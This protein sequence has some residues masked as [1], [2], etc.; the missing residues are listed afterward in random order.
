[1]TARSRTILRIGLIER[2]RSHMRLIKG[3]S[4]SV[5]YCSFKAGLHA[6]SCALAGRER[7]LRRGYPSRL[8]TLPSSGQAYAW[9]GR[10]KR[11]EVRGLK[12]RESAKVAGIF[13][14]STRCKGAGSNAEGGLEK[15]RGARKSKLF[16]VESV[17]YTG[18]ERNRS[19]SRN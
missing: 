18:H 10:M 14:I 12:R 6:M 17:A 7:A 5:V 15:V 1:M 4:Q 19:E 16:Y 8:P 2:A 11:A 3:M 9:A 13:H